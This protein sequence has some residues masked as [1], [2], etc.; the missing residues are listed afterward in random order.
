[1]RH[2]I[3]AIINRR[4][5]ITEVTPITTGNHNGKC[6]TCGE[7]NQFRNGWYGCW[8]CEI[9]YDAVGLQRIEDAEITAARYAH[10]L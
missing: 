7:S 1:M 4:L 5:V 6:P 8:S 2:K 9:E 3:L 10:S